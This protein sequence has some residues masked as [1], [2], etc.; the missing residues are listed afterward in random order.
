MFEAILNFF[1]RYEDYIL[2]IKA[3]L[4]DIIGYVSSWSAFQNYTKQLGK[5]SGEELLRQFE[6]EFKSALGSGD[7][8]SLRLRFKYFLLIGRKE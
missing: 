3:S 5:E 8:D 4:K 6:D 7:A 1:L 2:E